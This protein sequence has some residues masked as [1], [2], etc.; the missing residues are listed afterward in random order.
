MVARRAT[1]YMLCRAILL[2]SNTIIDSIDSDDCLFDFSKMPPPSKRKQQARRA[3]V[4]KP[5]FATITAQAA[6]E[7]PSLDEIT[8]EDYGEGTFENREYHDHVHWEDLRTDG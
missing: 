1:Y 5:S 6:Q 3:A 7:L 8:S 2:H 4:G